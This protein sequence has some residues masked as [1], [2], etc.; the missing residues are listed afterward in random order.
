MS[1]RKKVG[2]KPA[3]GA[4]EAGLSLTDRAYRNLEEMIVTLALPPAS[5]VSETALSRAWVS[6]ARP[7]ARHCSVSHASA[8]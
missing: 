6:G 8:W 7:Y 4:R 2:K 3:H 5:A 1:T